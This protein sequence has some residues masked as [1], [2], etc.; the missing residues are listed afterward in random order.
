MQ[1]QT[2][3]EKVFVIDAKA[4]GGEGFDVTWPGLRPLV[5]YVKRQRLRQRGHFDVAGALVLSSK[6]QQPDA[7]LQEL[8]DQFIGEA[9]V[10]ASF[11]EAKVLSE[12]V[13]AVRTRPDLRNA[14]G[15][16]SILTGGRVKLAAFKRE[17]AATDAER[18]RRGD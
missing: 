7:R 13:N 12:V 17:L 5:E 14:V 3:Q 9:G 6:F 1:A 15:W 18:V 10:P 8:S 16:S 11:M 2:P 4:A